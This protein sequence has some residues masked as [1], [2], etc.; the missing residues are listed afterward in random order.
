MIEYEVLNK[1]GEAIGKKQVVRSGLVILKGLSEKMKT[2]HRISFDGSGILTA[3]ARRAEYTV[4]AQPPT[5]RPFGYEEH[6]LSD[7]IEMDQ[8]VTYMRNIPQK[9]STDWDAAVPAG[10]RVKRVPMDEKRLTQEL[11]SHRMV[12]PKPDSAS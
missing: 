12:E 7:F 9:K 10:F 4:A 2:A 5:V 1:E 6:L 3:N 11:T 8:V